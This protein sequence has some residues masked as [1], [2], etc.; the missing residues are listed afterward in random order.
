LASFFFWLFLASFWINTE[1]SNF[2]KIVCHPSVKVGYKLCYVRSHY[3]GF[4][5]Y[6]NINLVPR[7]CDP[8]EGTWGI[9]LC[10]KPGILAKDRTAH[11]ISTANQ[12]LPWN[13]LS[14]S[15]TFL[16][17][18]RRLGERDWRKYPIGIS[19]LSPGLRG[20]PE[21]RENENYKI[22]VFSL[23]S[24]KLKFM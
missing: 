18:D 1:I 3:P 17:E 20:R 24:R 2:S 7:A 6:V 16:P 23:L 22:L 12:I 14:Q 15:L 8:R 4:R 13:G 9:I 21:R 10:R 11:S 5:M 19:T